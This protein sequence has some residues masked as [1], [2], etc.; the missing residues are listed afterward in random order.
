MEVP[1]ALSSTVNPHVQN[2]S[3]PAAS[4]VQAILD[5]LTRERSFA[6]PAAPTNNPESKGAI[7]WGLVSRRVLQVS[8]T[9]TKKKIKE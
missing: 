4:I 2:C 6:R 3:Y 7:R 1:I 9:K 5:N 8:E